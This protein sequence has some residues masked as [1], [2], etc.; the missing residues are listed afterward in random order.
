MYS[1]TDSPAQAHLHKKDYPANTDAKG[2][3]H[4]IACRHAWNARQHSPKQNSRIPFPVLRSS[5]LE[6]LFKHRYGDMLPDDDAGRD[7]LFVM[8]CHL[9][10]CHDAKRKMTGWARRWAP[11]FGDEERNLLVARILGSPHTWKPDT[12]AHKLGLT[13]ADR[14]Q[15]RIKTIGAVDLDQQ[16]RKA[17]RALNDKKHKEAKRRAAGAIPRAEYEANSFSR[18]K[19]WEAV[20]MSERTWRRKGKPTLASQTT[21]SGLSEVL[22]QCSLTGTKSLPN[23]FGQRSGSASTKFRAPRPSAR[24]AKTPSPSIAPT[25]IGADVTMSYKRAAVTPARVIV[26]SL[27]SR[28]LSLTRTTLPAQRYNLSHMKDAPMTDPIKT[29][30]D[31]ALDAAAQRRRDSVMRSQYLRALMLHPSWRRTERGYGVDDDAS[32]LSPEGMVEWLQ[33]EHPAEARRIEREHA[34]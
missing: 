19:P 12:L 16:G 24:A 18:T 32:P 13:M 15:L 21:L 29:M 30:L 5:E 23:Y 4:E 31:E 11:W 28:A 14:M 25:P 7:D 20:G 9:A 27:M 2:K 6:R 8:L 1:Q 26:E 3:H 10:R 34:A 17:R 22:R 33:R